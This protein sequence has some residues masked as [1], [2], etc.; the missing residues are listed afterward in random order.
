MK[1][2]LLYQRYNIG[3]VWYYSYC[4]DMISFQHGGV[5]RYAA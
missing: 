3:I 1:L 5:C 2:R 4:K